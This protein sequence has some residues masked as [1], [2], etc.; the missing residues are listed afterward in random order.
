[1]LK[2]HRRDTPFSGKTK[3][4]R[5]AVFWNQWTVKLDRYFPR[6]MVSVYRVPVVFRLHVIIAKRRLNRVV[7]CGCLIVFRC[8]LARVCIRCLIRVCYSRGDVF[9]GFDCDGSPFVRVASVFISCTVSCVSYRTFRNFPIS[10]FMEES[11]HSRTNGAYK[12]FGPDVGVFR[13]LVSVL[14]VFEEDE[15]LFL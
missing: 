14:R 11:V 1:M 10:V 2:D 15:G 8:L 6:I 4:A 7:P 5:V 9:V 13:G 3:S 12:D